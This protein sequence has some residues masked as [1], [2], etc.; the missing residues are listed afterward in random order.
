M[1]TLDQVLAQRQKPYH[2]CPDATYVFP[3]G[4][5][6]LGRSI[7]T[8]MVDQGARNIVFTSRSGATKPEA[9]KLLDNLARKGARTKAFACDISHASQLNQVLEE[10][11]V[12]FPPIRGVITGTMH[13]Q[14]RT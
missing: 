1:L 13:L 9:Q 14:V 10:I 6:G 7:A 5:G 3:G 2:F 12:D 4:L 8:W 11:K